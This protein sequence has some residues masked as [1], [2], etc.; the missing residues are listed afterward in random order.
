MTMWCSCQPLAAVGRKEAHKQKKKKKKKKTVTKRQ[1]HSNTSKQ[2][3]THILI[4]ALVK[5]MY[6]I[7]SETHTHIH[8]SRANRPATLRS[9]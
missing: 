8:R 3:Y 9:T 5:L 2:Q 6:N 1:T 4:N 7:L